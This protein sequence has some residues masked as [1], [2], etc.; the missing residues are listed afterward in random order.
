[1]TCP[2][3]FFRHEH[4]KALK[5][6]TFGTARFENKLRTY[7]M[8]YMEGIRSMGRLSSCGCYSDYSHAEMVAWTDSFLDT[9]KDSEDAVRDAFDVIVSVYEDFIRGSHRK[10]MD[11]LWS[12]LEGKGLL[13]QYASKIWHTRLL[14]R[15]RP[16]GGFDES[17]KREYFHVPFSKRHRIGNHRFSVSG[18]PLLYCGSSVLVTA[19]ELNRD[20]SELAVAGF[21]P[22]YSAYSDS[23]IYSLT[24]HIGECIENSLPGICK[25]GARIPYDSDRNA[26]NLHTIVGDMNQAV[27]MEVCTFPVESREA[28]V[29]EY[30]VPQMLT[31]ALLEHGFNGIVYPST[32]DY[33]DLKGYHRFSS[34][35]LNV[36]MFVPYDEVNDTNED[37]LR[38]VSA[39]TLSGSEK[40]DLTPEKLLEEMDRIVEV[41]KGSTRNNTDYMLPIINLTLHLEYMAA[42]EASGT[43]YFQTSAGLVELELYMKMLRH[44]EKLVL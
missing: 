4:Q 12:H 15:G 14:F 19:R 8:A 3:C 43:R 2:V 21:L 33:S 28:F 44:L 32:K 30:A 26:P 40:L 20:V 39:F 9:L 5:A 22:S 13:A 36:A 31:T 38:T 16:K 25:S 10:A 34:H 35:Q 24:N 37:L 18:Q 7:M 23:R 17:N 1:M 42:S 6:A 41:N 27:L 11:R 29:A